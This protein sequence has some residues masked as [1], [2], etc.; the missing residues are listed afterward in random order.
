MTVQRPPI[1][2][3]AE[4]ADQTR[5]RILDAAILIFSEKGLAGARTEEIAAAAQINKAMLYYYFKSKQQLYDAALEQAV[6]DA[7]AKVNATIGQGHSAGERLLYFALNH[8]DRLHSRQTLHNLMHQEMA[9]MK[10]GEKNTAPSIVERLFQ[11]MI[12]QVGKLIAEGQRKGELID[13]SPWQIMNT[14]LGANTFYFLSAPVIGMATG[15][16]LFSHKELARQRVA[17]IELLG[18]ALFCNRAHGA[19]VA[20]KVLDSTPMPA[21]GNLD[22]WQHHWRFHHLQEKHK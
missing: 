2:T 12:R 13:A 19:S 10:H 6:D 14:A 20:K 3:Q 7:L 11:P 1:R 16:D 15:R 18:K 22:H 8:F 17:A 5:A 9:R 4:R 21:S